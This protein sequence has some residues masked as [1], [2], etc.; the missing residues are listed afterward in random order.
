MPPYLKV[1]CCFIT[2]LIALIPTELAMG[3]FLS[4]SHL[5]FWERF[6]LVIAS[7]AVMWWA[8]MIL[9]FLGFMVI[10]FICLE[11]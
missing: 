3:L 11:L 9:L 5:T 7:I 2:A 4:S 10:L 1:I 6:A 8:Q